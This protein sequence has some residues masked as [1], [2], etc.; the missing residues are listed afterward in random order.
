MDDDSAE[1]NYPWNL[2]LEEIWNRARK[3]T[4]DTIHFKKMSL[5]AGLKAAKAQNNASS[6]VAAY[7]K[8]LVI[9][10][11]IVALGTAAQ[12]V[13]V[14]LAYLFPR[15]QCPSASSRSASIAAMQPAPAAV[16]AW[17]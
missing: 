6:A 4:T 10:T 14:S 17:R 8:W 12:A 2:T 5:L 9:F 13:F 7:T 11:V 15:S 16:M 3:P 1:L